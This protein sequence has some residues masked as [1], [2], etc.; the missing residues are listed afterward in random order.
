MLT[1]YLAPNVVRSLLENIELKIVLDSPDNNYR[2]EYLTTAIMDR[3]TGEQR[4]TRTYRL[5]DVARGVVTAEPWDTYDLEKQTTLV[6]NLLGTSH[7]RMT[8][9]VSGWEVICPA[10]G[11]VMQGKNWESS[12]KRCT[13]NHPL[14]C[15]AN[16]GDE[17]VKEILLADE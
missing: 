3:Q 4:L 10:C 17:I 16:I 9:I 2:F 12:P 1:D 15:R 8:K 7:Y 11:S 5:F 13:A 14:K 6:T